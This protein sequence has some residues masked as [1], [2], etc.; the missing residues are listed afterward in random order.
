MSKENFYTLLSRYRSG[1]CTNQEKRLV[2]QW[3]ATLDEEFPQRSNQ[4]NEAIEE[5]IW[6]VI[7]HQTGDEKPV[8]YTLLWKWAAA[9]MVV[10]AFAWGGYRYR[11]TQTLPLAASAFRS[12]TNK[13]L[14]T[15]TNTSAIAQTFMLPDSSEIQLSPNSSISYQPHFKEIKREVYL[16]GEAFFHVKRNIERPFFVHTGEVVTKVLGTSFWVSGS[17][18]NNAIEVSVVTGKVSVSH[19]MKANLTETSK[20]KDGVI[21]TANQRVKYTLQTHS[22]ETGLVLNPVLVATDK[23]GKPL[24]ESFVFADNPFSDVI[25]KLEKAYGIEIILEDETFTG[26]LFNGNIT[27]QPLFTKL[28]MLCSSVNATYEVRGTRILISGKGCSVTNLNPT[29]DMK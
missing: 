12:F 6:N 18:D 17:K 24:E 4:E 2:E 27:K 5:R 29:S 10:L 22:F 8:V 13:N 16:K 11:T 26:C 20:I 7:Q 25:D 3:F 14:Y 1:N 9:A 23:K 19:Q 21:L 28:D 15:K